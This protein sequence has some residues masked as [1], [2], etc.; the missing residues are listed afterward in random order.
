MPLTNDGQYYLNDVHYRM[1]VTPGIY[2]R[3]KD[4]AEDRM[5]SESAFEGWIRF[6]EDLGLTKQLEILKCMVD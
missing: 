3:C 6:M 5:M 4:I 2:N 1:N